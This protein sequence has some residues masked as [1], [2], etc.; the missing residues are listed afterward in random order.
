M[1]TTATRG[2]LTSHFSNSADD[3]MLW[4]H[5]LPAPG[6]DGCSVSKVRRR[7]PVR[8]SSRSVVRHPVLAGAGAG[9]ASA[10]I[11]WDF[12][13]SSLTSR[14][15]S[16][17]DRLLRRS[18][19]WPRLPR[20]LGCTALS[21]LIFHHRLRHPDGVLVRVRAALSATDWRLPRAPADGRSLL[22]DCPG[23]PSCSSVADSPA[24]WFICLPYGG[25]SCSA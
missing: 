12:V 18:Y 15:G 3:H 9:L 11:I 7:C 25:F 1:P 6:P 23:S 22:L 8:S 5:R 10:E 20:P 4:R 14:F 19:P 13:R 24:C 2:A 16:A 17:S 21:H